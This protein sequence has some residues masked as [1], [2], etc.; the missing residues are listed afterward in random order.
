MYTYKQSARIGKYRTRNN[1]SVLIRCCEKNN[2]CPQ[3]ARGFYRALFLGRVI[4][5]STLQT[6]GAY[7]KMY[8]SLDNHTDYYISL[9]LWVCAFLPVPGPQRQLLFVQKRKK[10]QI[11]FFFSLVSPHEFAY[12]SPW[13]RTHLGNEKK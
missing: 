6:A 1:V 8:F 12:G 4:Q 13:V 10:C 2:W 3:L 5:R 7:R 11:V 9:R